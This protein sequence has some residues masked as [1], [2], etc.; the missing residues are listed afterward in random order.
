MQGGGSFEM[1]E[2]VNPRQPDQTSHASQSDVTDIGFNIPRY[3]CHGTNGE[4]KKN[5]KSGEEFVVPLRLL[6]TRVIRIGFNDQQPDQILQSTALEH[7]HP[8]AAS[9]LAL[10]SFLI[11]M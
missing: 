11:A 2:Q 10:V 7:D 4:S 5:H 9:F 3:R 8:A 1:L 6:D